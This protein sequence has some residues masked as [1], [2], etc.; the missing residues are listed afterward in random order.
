[1]YSASLFIEPKFYTLCFIAL[2]VGQ[3]TV[4]LIYI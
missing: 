4:F 1:M 2:G 3:H